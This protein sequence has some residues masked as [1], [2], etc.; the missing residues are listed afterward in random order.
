M[1]GPLGVSAR[2]DP[3]VDVISVLL[4]ETFGAGWHLRHTSSSSARTRTQSMLASGSPGTTRIVTSHPG[5][6]AGVFTRFS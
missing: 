6:S 4:S 5:V 3:V 2:G 1:L